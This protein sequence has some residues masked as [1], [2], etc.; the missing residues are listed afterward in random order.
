MGIRKGRN[1]GHK[2]SGQIPCSADISSL[3]RS[4]LYH[5]LWHNAVMNE[6]SHGGGSLPP[7]G[8]GYYI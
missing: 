2:N 7:H 5:Y 1:L 8:E 6:P 4:S 3:L